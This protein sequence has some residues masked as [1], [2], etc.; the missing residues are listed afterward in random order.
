MLILLGVD[1]LQLY[2]VTYGTVSLTILLM[3]LNCFLGINML[4]SCH[5]MYYTL[6]AAMLMYC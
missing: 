1:V 4:L 3:F 6:H 5:I 2:N